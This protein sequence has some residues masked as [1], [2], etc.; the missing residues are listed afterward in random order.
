[1]ESTGDC[2]ALIM[3]ETRIY[4]A[5]GHNK[6][7]SYIIS[8]TPPSSVCEVGDVYIFLV[9]KLS[10]PKGMSSGCW[11]WGPDSGQPVSQSKRYCSPLGDWAFPPTF[12]HLFS[13]II[14]PLKT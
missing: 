12:L 2:L 10:A 11:R 6:S 8:V 14:T 3:K 1:M 9:R 4:C 13:P 5:G 7:S